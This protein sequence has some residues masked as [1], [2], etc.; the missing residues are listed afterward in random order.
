MIP[1]GYNV[2]F[3]ILQIISKIKIIKKQYYTHLFLIKEYK[4]Q[5]L[6]ESAFYF[7]Y[8]PAI[9]AYD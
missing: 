6:R 2:M 5:F 4:K 7:Q 9:S 1:L 3:L 8:S